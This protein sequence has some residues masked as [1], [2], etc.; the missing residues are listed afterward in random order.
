MGNKKKYI[1]EVLFL[2]VVFVGTVYGVFH[3]EDLGEVMQALSEVRKVWL[4]PAVGCVVLFLWGEAVT[5]RYLLGIQEIPVTPGACFLFSTVGFFF[6]CI[7]PSASGGQPMQLYYMRR[8]NIPLPIATLVL[9]VITIAYKSVL[10]LLG[11]GIILFGQGFV[12]RYLMDI[13]PIFYFGIGL[14]ILCVGLL[15]LLVFR[16]SLAKAILWKLLKLLEKLHVLHG[17]EKLWDRAEAAIGKYEQSAAFFGTHKAV[18]GK[19]FA[20]TFLQ[21][22]AL[23]SSTYFVYLAFGLRGISPVTI[24]LLQAVISIAADMMPLPGGMGISETLFLAIFDPIF[25]EALLLPGMVLSRGL[26]YYTELFISALFTV[27]AH[28]VL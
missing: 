18:V 15:L 6:N 8:K 24:V 21:R 16:T 14:N 26:S 4:L 17:S 7:T 20:I 2:L 12:H 28:F 27:V 1:W 10:V 3:G 22:I 9:M 25:G 19:V 11:L 23:F 5:L 13:L